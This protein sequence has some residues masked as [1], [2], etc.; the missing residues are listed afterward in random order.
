MSLA[1]GKTLGHFFLRVDEMQL[2]GCSLEGFI[3]LYVFLSGIISLA[4]DLLTGAAHHPR[5]T[6]S[7]PVGAMSFQQPLISASMIGLSTTHT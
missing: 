3:L 5:P 4:A 1:I 2:Y 6:T 7:A